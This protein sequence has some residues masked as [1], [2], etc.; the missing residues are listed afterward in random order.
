[1]GEVAQFTGGKVPQK[2]KDVFGGDNTDLSSGVRGG[3]SVLS[4]RGSRW[5]VKVGDDETTVT[6]EDGDAVGSLR[7][8]LLKGKPECQ[9]ELLLKEL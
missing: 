9:Q 4:I 8:V 1:M 7:L 6:N 5:H 2:L 3:Y